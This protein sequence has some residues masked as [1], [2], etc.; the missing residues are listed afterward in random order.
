MVDLVPPRRMP[1]GYGSLQAHA[2]D[3]VDRRRERGARGE[4][5]IRAVEQGLH[6]EDEAQVVG[7]TAWASVPPPKR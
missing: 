1:P 6:R 7:V 3:V 2:V 5:P 4:P